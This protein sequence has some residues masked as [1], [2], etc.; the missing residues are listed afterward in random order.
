MTFTFTHRLG[1]TLCATASLLF[2]GAASAEQCGDLTCNEGF[3]CHSY[4]SG[5]DASYSCDRAPCTSDDECG[6]LM[7]CGTYENDCQGLS[8]ACAKGGCEPG[9]VEN[10]QPEFQQC[11]PTWE[12][13]CAADADCGEGFDCVVEPACKDCGASDFSWCREQ[14]VDCTEDSDCPTHWQCIDTG[15]NPC[16]LGETC[17]EGSSTTCQPPDEVY[18]DSSGPLV[19][20]LA[21][22]SE[23]DPAAQGEVA[24]LGAADPNPNATD[25]DLAAAG[26]P[27]QEIAQDEAANDSETP[28]EGNDVAQMSDGPAHDSAGG[29]TVVSA[30]GG[31]GSGGLAFVALGLGAMLVAR[32]RR[33]S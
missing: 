18:G 9:L 21:A 17:P 13:P 1:T 10:C 30:P 23:L 32:R 4:G 20:E 16:A 24:T 12:L 26:T 27:A 3:V 14:V 7:V 29:C 8:D 28:V 15:L 25:E 11:A 31:R 2:A 6:P 33:T 5:D 22:S 19:I